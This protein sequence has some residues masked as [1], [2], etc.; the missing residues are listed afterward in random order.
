[1]SNSIPK[2]AACNIAAITL[3]ILVMFAG[4]ACQNASHGNFPTG[5][6]ETPSTLVPG[7]IIKVEFTGAP[8]LDQ[9]QLIRSD[10]KITLPLVGE[11]MAAGKTFSQFQSELA[12]LYKVQLKNSE[13]TISLESGASP[14]VVI[15]GSV[16]RP[17]SIPCDKP[18]T[19][20]DAIM[21]AGGFTED[22]N[23]RN[24]RL[25]RR[26]NGEFVCKI[27]DMRAVANGGVVPAEP[28]QGGDI[29]VVSEKLF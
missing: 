6:V 24:V 8:E 26:V 13:V 20:F 21:E 3:A 5:A 11:V 4:A 9:S 1:M 29:I 28:V 17:G 25:Y 10:G 7:N 15:D 18:L 16:N 22:A 23:L 14:A 27:M 12:A 2:K 19:A